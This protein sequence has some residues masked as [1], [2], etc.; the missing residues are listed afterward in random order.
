LSWQ[1][2]TVHRE[3]AELLN[4][5]KSVWPANKRPFL[6]RGVMLIADSVHGVGLRECGEHV[7]IKAFLINTIQFS[8]EGCSVFR[9]QGWRAP[10]SAAACLLR[11]AH[12]P[13]NSFEKF[14]VLS[15]RVKKK[16]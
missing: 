12:R 13:F 15:W 11:F 14:S 2:S 10:G 5:S 1:L 4:L 16:L 8:W 7:A 3:G 6:T 9:V